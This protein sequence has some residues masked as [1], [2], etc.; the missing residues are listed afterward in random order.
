VL[1]AVLS[2]FG[3]SVTEKIAVPVLI[4]ITPDF[5]ENLSEYTLSGA[6]S[7]DIEYEI[8]EQTKFRSGPGRETAPG[9][10]GSRQSEPGLEAH[11]A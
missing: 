10:P 3:V 2:F 6:E 11:S 9:E 4:Q 5:Y 8:K 7:V 1:S